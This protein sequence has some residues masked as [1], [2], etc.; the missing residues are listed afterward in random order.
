MY[1]ITLTVDVGTISVTLIKDGEQT[2]SL[3]V[4]QSEILDDDIPPSEAM[5]AVVLHLLTD[6]R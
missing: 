6:G 1:T 3:L 5:E 2:E 4:S